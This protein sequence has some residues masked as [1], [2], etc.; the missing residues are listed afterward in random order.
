MSVPGLTI[1]DSF[2][3]SGD[4][5]FPFYWTEHPRSKIKRCNLSKTD[6]DEQLI[7][8]LRE[9]TPVPASNV[10]GNERDREKLTSLLSNYSSLVMLILFFSLLF[11][12]TCIGL[13]FHFLIDCY[14]D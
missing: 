8:L 9:A 5:L 14:H 3:T 2:M 12:F 13:A 1:L 11:F 10:L 7:S 4:P 6:V